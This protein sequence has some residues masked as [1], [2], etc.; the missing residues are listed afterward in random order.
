M[1]DLPN[2]GINLMWGGLL[3]LGAAGVLLLAFPVL[4]VFLTWMGTGVFVSAP[5]TLLVDWVLRPAIILVVSGVVGRLAGRGGWPLSIVAAS[6][7]VLST[8]FIRGTTAAVVVGAFQ[9]LVAGIGGWT[10]SK[11]QRKDSLK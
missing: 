6:P 5:V 2:H 8:A 3:A 1:S 11:L 9:L 7:A 10:G 4:L